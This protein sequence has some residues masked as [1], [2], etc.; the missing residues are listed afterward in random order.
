MPRERLIH[1]Y[2]T[3]KVRSPQ[4]NAKCLLLEILNLKNILDASDVV[5]AYKLAGSNYENSL[6]CNVHSLHKQI[7]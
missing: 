7:E 6:K 5:A 2:D 4:Q 3:E 1:G